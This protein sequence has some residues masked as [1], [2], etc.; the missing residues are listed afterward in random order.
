MARKKPVFNPDMK[1]PL[2]GLQYSKMKEYAVWY[3]G[4]PDLLA[5][6]YIYVKNRN[7]FNTTY[8][9]DSN[10]FW[11]RQKNENVTT[12]VV[13]VPVASSMSELSS[14]LLF[15]EAPTIRLTEAFKK[16]AS[17]EAIDSQEVLKVLLDES[18]FE[19]RLVE[20]AECGSAIGG[21][22]LKVAV[23]P[24]ILQYPFCVIEQP[25]NAL[26]TFRFGRLYEV[27]FVNLVFV[28]NKDTTGSTKNDYYRLMETYT[29]DGQILYALHKGTVDKLGDEVDLNALELTEDLVNK[30]T[31]YKGILVQYVPNMLPNRL[32]R[33]SCYGRSDYQ[34]LESLMQVLDETYSA[35]MRDIVLSKGKVLVPTAYL[36]SVAGDDSSVKELKYD[37]DKA[38]YA[39]LNVDPMDTKFKMEAVQFAIRADDFEKT[40]LNLIERIVSSAGYSPQSFGLNISGRV[41]S[42]EALNVREKKSYAKKSKKEKYWK[43]AIQGIIKAL[44]HVYNTEFK[45]SGTIIESSITAEFSDGLTNDIGETSSAIKSIS[46]YLV[47]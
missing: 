6:Y 9:V 34:G 31:G 4:E 7:I 41:E 19:V 36:E 20:G 38:F 42:G 14:D 12:S 23:D 15:G 29:I 24:D 47:L 27:T 28:D 30:S 2:G 32:D 37:V 35:W 11:A 1:F 18:Q 44:V 13:H 33:D 17:K 26:P 3:A 22:Y 10:S 5:N 40:C 25:D 21:V 8:Q 16:D 45:T 46:A 39:Q 43:P